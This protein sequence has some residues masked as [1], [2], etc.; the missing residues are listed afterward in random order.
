MIFPPENKTILEAR[1]SF[2]GMAPTTMLAI[3]TGEFMKGKPWANETI[4]QAT[5]KLLEEFPLPAGV[6]GGMV[7]YRQSLTVSFLL[8]AFFRISLQ[9]NLVS[10]L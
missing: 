2:G 5:E 7:R 8:K 4:E 6:P 10:M 9:S 3:K 1:A